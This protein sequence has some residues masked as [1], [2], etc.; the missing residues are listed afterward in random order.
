MVGPTRRRLLAAGS[1]L[2]AS[3]FFVGGVEN[4]GVRVLALGDS[5][6]VGTGVDPADRWVDRLASRL[7]SDGVPVVDPEVVAAN[8][9]T[10]DRLAG[11]IDRRSLAPPYDLVT[12]LIGANDAFQE[13]A[14]EAFRRAFEDL[15]EQAVAF[16]GGR[17]RDVVVLTIP[18]Y[19]V[20]PVGRRYE[21][22]EHAERLLAYNEVVRE[23]AAASGV[24]LVDLVGVS[25]QAA[26]EPGL[27]AADG[28]HPSPEQHRRWLERIYPVARD[29][30]VE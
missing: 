28:L 24:R 21:P 18:D 13:R 5:Y 26:D 11:A 7:R 22:A 1:A 29:V 4:P 23:T 12:L 2:V 6:T 27:V 25:R 8:G 17:P 19:T 15:L 3:T 9:W 30:L 20:T 16:A 14:V 10:T